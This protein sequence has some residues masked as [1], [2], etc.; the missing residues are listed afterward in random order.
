MGL[1]VYALKY[2][3][4]FYVMSMLILLAGIGGYII[5]PKDVLPEVNIPVVTVVWTYTGLDTPE[6][7][8]RVTTYAEVSISNNVSNI[9]RMESTTL[10]GITV[11]RIYF[12]SNVSIDLAISQIV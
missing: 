12:Q 1:V 4:T 9:R 7:E 3:I 8:S 2:R 6:M 11:Q 10:Q 5:M